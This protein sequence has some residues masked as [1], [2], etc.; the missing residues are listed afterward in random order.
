[1]R[2]R[3][4]SILLCL[5]M[6]VGL[7]PTMAFAAD[8][9]G[10]TTGSGTK[11][12]PYCVSTYDEMKRL[13]Q[14]PKSYYIKVVGMDNDSANEGVPIRRLTAGRDFQSTSAAIKIPYGAHHHLEIATDVWF[15]ADRK[16]GDKNIFSRLIDVESGS[17]LEI[18]G[19]GSLRVEVNALTVKNAIIDNWGGELTIDGSV[20]LNGIQDFRSNVATR[21][22]WIDG[23]VTNIKGGYIYGHNNMKAT[24]DDVTSAIS[25]GNN[26]AYGT[27]LNISGG[28]I[29]QVNNKTNQGNE[30]SCALYVKN[31]KVADAIHLTGG[32]FEGGIKMAT[33]KPLSNLLTA[34]YQFYDMD[35]NTVFDGS[36][37]KTQKKLIVTPTGV[38][39]PTVIDNVSLTVKSP[40]ERKTLSDL[41]CSYSPNNKMVLANFCVYK[42]QKKTSNEIKDKN[43]LYDANQDYTVMYVFKAN[44]GF[45]FST[46]SSSLTDVNVSVS[47]GDLWKADSFGGL[48]DT[49][50]VFVYFPPSTIDN[51]SLTIKS[52]NE[53]KA[54][55]DLEC[56]YSPNSK[57]VLANFYVYKGL[58]KTSNEIKDKNTLYDA[59][60]DY[61][62]MYVF[63]ANEGFSF[64]TDSSSLSDVNVSVSGGDLW[65]AD[66]FGGLTNTLR[67]FVTFSGVTPIESVTLNVPELKV[68]DTPGDFT[69]SGTNTGVSAVTTEWKDI[70][71]TGVVESTSYS[72]FVR[73]KA[74][75][76]YVFDANTNVTLIGDY[77]GSNTGISSDGKTM[78]VLVGV[79]ILHK[80]TFGEWKDFGN[81]EYHIRECSCL[82]QEKEPHEWKY[83]EGQD[84][85]KCTVCGH[86][87]DGEKERI[88]YVYASPRSP[89]AGEHPGDYTPAEWVKI[90]GTNYKVESIVWKNM[91]DTDVT[92]FEAG[93]IYKGTVTFKANTGFAFDGDRIYGNKIFDSSNAEIVGNYSL[94]DGG[95]TL[96]A[97][98]KLKDN[99]V[100]RPGLQVKVKL[101]TLND[102]IGQSFPAAELVDTTL[103]DDVELTSSVY[104]D[105][106]GAP[107]TGSVA[108]NKTYF[109]AVMLQLKGGSDVTKAY[110]VSYTV[111]DGGDAEYHTDNLAG[112][113]ILARYQTPDTSKIN[114]VALTV[115]APKYGEAPATTATGANDTLYTVGTPTWS[116]AVTDGKFGAAAYTVSIPVTAKSGY[117]FDAN[118]L[119]TVNGYVATY[120]DG[121]V[122]YEFPALTAPHEHSYGTEWKYDETNHWHECECG[123]KADIAAHSASEWKPD[124][125]DDTKHY[126]ECSVCGHKIVANHV[127]S[128][129][130]TVT[131]AGI[132]TPGTWH[133][134][135]VDCGE[136]MNTGTIPALVKID[137]AKLTVAKPVKD[138]AAEMATT[139][140]STYYVANTEWTAADGATLDIGDK[141]K[142][143]T[144]YTVKITLE[145]KNSNVF[146]ADSTYNKIEGKDAKLVTAVTGYTDSVILTYTF[147]A[148]EGT[149]VPTKP[150]ITTV[151]LPDGKV[152]E[153]YN[154]TLAATGTNP[155]TWGIETGTLPDGLT[156]VG[157]T[158]KGTPSKAGEFKFTVKATNSGGSG[159]KELTIKI[160]DA[161]AAKYHY[162]TLSGA[163]TG[164]TGAGSHAE[165]TTVNIYAGTKSGYTFNGWTSDDVTVLS[166]SSKNASFVMPDKDVTVKANWVYTGG[167]STGGGYTYYTIKATA[168]VNGSISPT[169]NVSVREGRDQTF[170]ITPNKGYAVAKVLIDSK[171]V[172]AVKSY[173]FE[174]VKKNHTIEVVF[175][176]AS[177]NPQTGVFVD[178]PED[179]YYEEAVNW[180][181]EK[182]ITTGTDATHFSP[183]GI[184]TR[185]QAVTFLWRA[186]G[187][188]AAKSAVMPFTDVKAGSYYYD[189]VLWAVENGITK[190]TSETMFSP[191]ATCS[192]AQIV[193]FLWRSQKSPAAGTANPFTDVKASAYYADA[194]LWAV[195]EDVT[196]G[197][198]NTTFSPDANCTRAQIVTFIWRALAE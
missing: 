18:T 102:K 3:I 96:T 20:T 176:K 114:S 83:L 59:N 45:S 193:T 61:T 8:G 173:T 32:I 152:G 107:I 146:T 5:V 69:L 104:E 182:G 93:K 169:G 64:S 54:L 84:K 142:S 63:K 27:E 188:P 55:S 58:K 99:T 127:E 137:V 86:E 78:T 90:G 170:T 112:Y 160:A 192:R 101:P 56:S 47:G 94:A 109:Y 106:F 105:I 110:N 7:F 149:Y 4:L 148:T 62:V 51:V 43:T 168:G 28:T 194:V 124:T 15:V 21:P 42:G 75:N 174:N 117:T 147:D 91:D 1:M 35:A 9:S 39:N 121:K 155:I 159:T 48:T 67:I 119:Y 16:D 60:Q 177:G 25:F 88:G 184:C 163:G 92:T 165:R 31:N 71:A 65:K 162:V 115:T 76:G 33:G 157:D 82:A 138:A 11:S 183:D 180:A 139:G 80:H 17:S 74:E 37:S 26:L 111:T 108:Q 13:L 29:K 19:T 95:T 129:K 70:P 57:M 77:W 143:G 178:V 132:G 52:Q 100:V 153:A 73:L 185:A 14:T 40:N 172:G 125:A 130:I 186:A 34:G 81:S 189:A 30:N 136:T 66:S 10:A 49:L 167:G 46:D 126:K 187:S 22:I 191:D 79:R 98:F 150:A 68:G 164:A 196:K 154:Q 120:A 181:V 122:S 140:D 166:A 175:M 89:I 135:C 23:G 131:P 128:N 24:S 36:V 161:E 12:D 116:P 103:P 97:T 171:N 156:L 141:F 195:K 144:A 85:Y 87:I 190:G 44:E 158:I 53:R 134:V 133:T 179:S 118:C 6:V 113:G 123:D 38:D 2:K 41:A 145:A 198:T 72:A 197:T 151:T 50:R